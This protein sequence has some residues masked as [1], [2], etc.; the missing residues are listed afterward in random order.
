MRGE[1]TIAA[2]GLVCLGSACAL[3]VRHATVPA[4][5]MACP[6]GCPDQLPVQG[7]AAVDE[8]LRHPTVVEQARQLVRTSERSLLA[9]YE[10][11]E[12]FHPMIEEEL[13][14][15][16]IPAE[17]GLIPLLESSYQP[18]ATGRSVRGLWQL[19]GSTARAYGLTVNGRVD[20][21]L[22]PRK[23]TR[24]AAAYLDDLYDQFDDWG[25]AIA[26][27]NA[28]P[29]RIEWALRRRPGAD[30]FDLA[31]ARLLP[32][33][34]RR[35]VPKLMATALALTEPE[36]LAHVSQTGRRPS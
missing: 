33:V 3:P 19:T 18:R 23:S 12:R 10:K 8:M 13:A 14:R 15:Q 9:N 6:R 1:I 17:L 24:A 21:R 29:A 31:R 4:V 27:Y 30:V 25:L 5:A 16:G 26:A 11:G 22:D 20:E 28:G 32:A 2:L 36:S 35:Y 7:Q 34:T